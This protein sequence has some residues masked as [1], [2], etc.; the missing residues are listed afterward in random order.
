[1]NK[2]AYNPKVLLVEEWRDIYLSFDQIQEFES[3]LDRLYLDLDLIESHKKKRDKNPDAA[4]DFKQMV[5]KD[6]AQNI[7][8][9]RSHCFLTKEEI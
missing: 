6:V 1:M 8:A 2:L 5:R 3:L 4:M 9:A 7:E